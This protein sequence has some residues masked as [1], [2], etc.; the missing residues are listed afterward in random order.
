M[1][2]IM[3]FIMVLS[4]KFKIQKLHRCPTIDK[5][6]CGMST[7]KYYAA[8]KS[9]KLYNLSQHGWN[10]RVSKKGDRYKVMF[11]ICRN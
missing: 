1:Y 11:P 6:S 9:T 2:T 4:L 5:Q 3:L 7:M 10:E 8:L